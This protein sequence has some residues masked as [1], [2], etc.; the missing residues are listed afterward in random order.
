MKAIEQ[1]TRRHHVPLIKEKVY[2]DG[3]PLHQLQYLQVKLILRGERFTSSQNLRDFSQFVAQA[4]EKSGVEFNTAGFEDLKPRI[5][6]V[7]FIDT[8]DF[9][10]FRNS[11]ILRR[12]LLYEDGFL[13]GDPEIVFKFRHPDLQ[14]AAE[15]D[16]RPRIAGDYRVKFKA[17]ALPLKERLGSFRMLYSHNVQFALSAV[18]QVDRLSMTTI[19][20]VL[21][22]LQTLQLRQRGRVTLVNN[23]AVEEILVD[24]GR[25]DFGK[26]V[27]SKCNVSLWRTRGD[28]QQLVGEFAF[29]VKFQHRTELHDKALGRCQ[30]FFIQL[31]RQA[32][33]WIALG[34]TKTGTVYALKGIALKSHE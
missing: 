21:P 25:L 1:T 26:G 24:I 22:A 17:E 20:E 30:D 29:Q 11:F 7:L 28:L 15:V 10:L 8:P 14:K 27:A 13:V 3:Q 19:L 18:R 34:T 16:V 32:Q 12:R 4:A 23:A 6:E 31:Q 33:D 2:R 5:R 9:L